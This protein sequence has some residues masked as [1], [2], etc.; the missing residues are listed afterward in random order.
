MLRTPSFPL[1]FLASGA[2]FAQNVAV[3]NNKPM[4]KVRAGAWASLIRDWRS[5]RKPGRRDRAQ[6][7]RRAPRAISA[8]ER[9]LSSAFAYAAAA[10]QRGYA[11][12]LG[13]AP[14]LRNELGEHLHLVQPGRSAPRDQRERARGYR[15]GQVR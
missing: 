4:P 3:V 10:P 11:R 7:C 8:P 1:A 15:R 6:A 9:R 5:C 2:A 13:S 12:P 14:A